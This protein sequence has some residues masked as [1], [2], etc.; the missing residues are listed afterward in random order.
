MPVCPAQRRPLADIEIAV[1][2]PIGHL[3]R[4]AGAG[5][6]AD[7]GLGADFTA[8][9]NELIGAESIGFLDGPGFVEIR[10]ALPDALLPGI[11]RDEA[12]A[13]PADDRR[14]DL[15]QRLDDIAAKAVFVRQV[16]ARV[17]NAA[18]DLPVEVLEEMPEDF[19][20]ARAVDVVGQDI[21]YC[22]LIH[23]SLISWT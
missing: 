18:V 21:E 1:F 12:A 8:E 14:L 3:F 16:A 20:V 2:H 13:G 7:E 19:E 17:I 6:G 9:G 4:C 15:A 22:F 10:H 23:R 11:S 5:V